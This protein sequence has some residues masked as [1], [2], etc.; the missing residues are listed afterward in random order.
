M[1]SQIIEK[2]EKYNWNN[3]IAEWRR[4]A[5]RE[6]NAWQLSKIIFSAA[7]VLQSRNYL[8]IGVCEGDS[9]I[10]FL[11]GAGRRNLENI[12][13]IDPWGSEYGGSG[14]KGPEHIYPILREYGVMEKTVILCGRSADKLPSIDEQ[15]IRFDL[16]TVDG[17]HSNAG[18]YFDLY[19]CWRLLAP[20]GILVFD[21][22]SHPK[23]RALEEV[24]TNFCKEIGVGD[25]YLSHEK[26][27]FGIVQ[28]GKE[29][30]K[31]VEI[32]AV[33]PAEIDG[34]KNLP[35][36]IFKEENTMADEKKEAAGT[37]EQA[38]VS[39]LNK[40]N[41]VHLEVKDSLKGYLDEKAAALEASNKKLN[42]GFEARITALEASNKKSIE[43][44]EA[45]LSALET[46]LPLVSSILTNLAGK[47]KQAGE[48]AAKISEKK[49]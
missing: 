47:L 15:A 19:N 4:S 1:L 46:N 12:C 21:D 17:D 48:D 27:G 39:A 49:S 3:N 30:R 45:R 20:E 40:M 29:S 43:G 14:R 8:E 42:E 6:G 5:Q 31:R 38:L 2:Y 22:I 25:F 32:D 28:K 41:A 10:S 18:A 11:K 37:K 23:H 36:V 16:I 34:I 7:S 26:Y 35:D 33:K 44:I 13:L 9:L 24:F